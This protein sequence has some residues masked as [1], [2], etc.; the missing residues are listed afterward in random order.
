LVPVGL[1]GQEQP[2]RLKIPLT[3]FYKPDGAV[4]FYSAQL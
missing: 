2:L 4:E 3:F 1:S